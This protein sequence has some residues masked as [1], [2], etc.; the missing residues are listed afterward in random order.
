MDFVPSE[1]PNEAVTKLYI[2][3]IMRLQFQISFGGSF[4]SLKV[5]IAWTIGTHA[6]ISA[7]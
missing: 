2:Q 5:W 7:I 6:S 4:D 3:L 1:A